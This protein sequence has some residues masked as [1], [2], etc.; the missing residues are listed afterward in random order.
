MPEAFDKTM[1]QTSAA[2]PS[3]ASPS[4]FG[5]SRKSLAAGIVA[6]F[7]LSMACRIP[8]LLRPLTGAHDWLTLQT[9]L[10]LRIWDEVG[11]GRTHAAVPMN[12]SNPADKFIHADNALVD[13]EGTAYFISFPPFAFHL[14]YLAHVI[15]PSVDPRLLLKGINLF[16]LLLASFALA[17]ILERIVGG[18][19][20]NLVLAA[21][22][23]F[24]FNRAVLMT[25][26]NLYFSVTLSVPLWI[27]AVSWYL[28]LAESEAVSTKGSLVLFVLMTLLCY[29]DWLGF[30]AAGTFF[31]LSILRR[32][33]RRPDLAKVSAGAAFL[34]ALVIVVQYSSVAGPTAFLRALTFRLRIRAGLVKL[35]GDDLTLWNLETYVSIYYNYM[36]QYRYLIVSL[37]AMA[38]IVFIFPGLWKGF[39][40][41]YRR[42]AAALLCF[43]VPVVLDHVLLANHTAHHDYAVLKA[44]PFLIVLWIVFLD[45]FA[46]LEFEYPRLRMRRSAPI[47]AACIVSLLEVRHYLGE[48]DYLV[49]RQ[50]VLGEAIKNAADPAGVVFLIRRNAADEVTPNLVYFATRNVKLV[51]DEND[52]LAFLRE[53]HRPAGILFHAD[54][55]GKLTAPPTRVSIS[56]GQK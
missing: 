19:R 40:E 18:D 42:A 21:I 36:L 49:P 25:L 5:L 8:F 10:T 33:C 53:H 27:L 7:L 35:P 15:G 14:A 4:S 28:K 20:R 17:G 34:A 47:V 46:G 52:A 41:R 13:S 16:L 9:M 11:V 30:L 22:A 37:A 55:D 3:T 45:V 56:P 39:R 23:M 48:R 1:D 24:L 6:L 31:A 2:M 44:V 54:L 50:A 43:L 32:D 12:Y 38:F 29:T 26:G 51:D